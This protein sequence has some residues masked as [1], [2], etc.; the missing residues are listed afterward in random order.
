MSALGMMSSAFFVPRTQ[1]IEWV[2]ATFKMSVCK[3]EQGFN[4]AIYCQVFDSIFPGKVS[5]SK[6]NW[7]ARD[8]YECLSNYK[9]LQ[10]TFETCNITRHVPVET[11]VRGKYQDNLEFLQWVKSYWDQAQCSID[12]DPVARRLMSTKAIPDWA[13]PVNDKENA[14]RERGTKRLA[15]VRSCH[16]ARAQGH[17]SIVTRDDEVEHLSD[18]LR[19]T[20]TK[21]ASVEAER[22]FYFTK[23]RNVEILCQDL[24]DRAEGTQTPFVSVDRV[25][26]ILYAEGSQ[27]PAVPVDVEVQK[28]RIGNGQQS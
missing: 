7:G 19:A 10:Q 1:L 2:N 23:L 12:Y 25:L 5:M 20:K 18:D 4:G 3:V 27:S 14:V 21:L 26:A 15:S 8:A 16:P 6:V 24:Q 28:D 9:V 22:D 13:L 17:R 11:L